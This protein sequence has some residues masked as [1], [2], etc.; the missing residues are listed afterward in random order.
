MSVTK[1]TR[2]EVLKR[3][4]FTCRY[5]RATD[6]KITVDHVVPVSLG[7]SD[8]P[9]NL[10]AACADCN[11]GKASASLD[12]AHVAE[13]T[14]ESLRLGEIVR[15]AYTALADQV[16]ARAHYAE[17][18]AA[19]TARMS[20]PT[21]WRDSIGRWHDMGVPYPLIR[22]AAQIAMSKTKVPP[23]GKFTYFCAIVWKQVQAV[24]AVSTEEYVRTAV[25][26]RYSDSWVDGYMDALSAL[27]SIVCDLHQEYTAMGIP[28]DQQTIGLSNLAKYL[29]ARMTEASGDDA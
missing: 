5:C 21:D 13:I 7:G 11:A 26:A 23:A 22:E 2:F 1:R 29:D 27:H 17:A 9:S 14:D 4:D 18:F 28:E 6:T 10:V 19:D 25:S 3:D 15:R 24:T 12:D 16:E 20:K 8:D